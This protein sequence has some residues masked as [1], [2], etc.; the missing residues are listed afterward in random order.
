MRIMKPSEE[1]MIIWN[2]NKKHGW[3]QEVVE[4]WIDF[5]DR[6]KHIT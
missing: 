2:H 3:Y 4:F 5:K 6:A 1:K